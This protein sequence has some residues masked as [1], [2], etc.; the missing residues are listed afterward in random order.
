MADFAISYAHSSLESALALRERLMSRGHSVWMDAPHE[1]AAALVGIPVGQSHWDVIRRELASARTVVVLDTAEWRERDYCQR[2]YRLCRDL[3]KPL[4][5]ITPAEEE[6]RAPAIVDSM[7]ENADLLAAHARLAARALTPQETRE[8]WLRSV[9]LGR[10]A[11]DA[12]AVIEAQNPPFALT[13]AIREIVDGDLARTDAARRRFRRISI[14]VIS[15]FAALAVLTT[16][17]WVFSGLWSRSASEDR[18]RAEALELSHLASSS[19]DTV[20]AVALARDAAALDPGPASAAVL[21][22]SE[23][24]DRRMRVL[25]IPPERYRGASWSADEDLIYAYSYSTISVIDPK[26]GEVR[27]S[28]RVNDRI[29]TGTVVAASALGVAYVNTLNQM[30]RLDMGSGESSRVREGVSTL[31]LATNGRLVGSGRQGS[32]FTMALSP[33]GELIE[34]ASVVLASHAR[35]IDVNGD[36]IGAIDDQGWLR[37]F[38]IMPGGI[39]EADAVLVGT[40]SLTD[41]GSWLRS[42]VTVCDDKL[43]GSFV[44]GLRG[45][46]FEWEP[47]TQT[48]RTERSMQKVASLCSASGGALTSA[49]PRG[50]IE[51]Q[52]SSFFITP[53]AGVEQ[54]WSVRDPNHTRAAFIS[55]VPGRLFFVDM[56][57]AITRRN[58]GAV[59]LLLPLR[60]ATVSIGN[61]FEVTTEQTQLGKLPGAPISW[62]VQGCNA[63]VL[64]GSGI[65]HLGCDSEASI[66]REPADIAGL[67]PAS[68][69]QRFVI[70]HQQ[71][72][73][74]RRADG[75]LERAIEIDPT[76]QR[77]VVEADLSPDGKHLLL[78]M[79]DGSIVE[80]AVDGEAGAAML[81]TVPPGMSTLVA[82]RPDGQIVV[83]GGD[84][85]LR[86]FDPENELTQSVQLDIIGDFLLIDAETILVTS[87]D[88]GAVVLDIETLRVIEEYDG[89]LAFPR[90]TPQSPRLGL[91][92]YP[93]SGGKV[94]SSELVTIPPT[95]L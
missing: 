93:G 86:L 39:V 24:R 3:G 83:L 19:V 68:D 45:T 9:L 22:S 31:A 82:Y 12:T 88:R 73:E 41:T 35:S 11:D 43:V 77:S 72:V 67:R 85:R 47:A 30:Q 46:S 49:L 64:T 60:D 71:G 89:I 44:P 33:E 56:S 5:F 76:G 54:M 51:E 91:V 4:E 81:T 37:T 69:G 7:R 63:L 36:T 21:A 25:E 48:V 42:T 32:L 62:A 52:F 40:G 38:D 90:A 55:A 78:A 74:V 6:T 80:Q 18:A 1:H 84:G 2:E 65:S 23:L 15:V 16:T 95:D 70:A 34:E 14:S 28:V 20:Q 79:S 58:I 50:D 53:P 87:L 10:T 17:A 27:T 59:R 66:V 8:P 75:S 26:T 94:E 13:P 57:S 61:E 29:R 92:V